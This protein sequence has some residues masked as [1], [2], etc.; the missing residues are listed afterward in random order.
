MERL[1]GYA[2]EGLKRHGWREVWQTLGTYDSATAATAAA[3]GMGGEVLE[4]RIVSCIRVTPMTT[5][6]T[7]AARPAHRAARSQSVLH[8]EA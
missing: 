3:K 2:V 8:V 6:V 1:I 5:H 7:V 4:T